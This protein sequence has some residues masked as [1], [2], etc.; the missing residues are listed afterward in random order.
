MS[1]PQIRCDHDQIQKISSQ[2]SA[3]S[4][5][6]AGINRKLKSA[7]ATL[8]GGDW[9]G[10]GATQFLKEMNNEINPA[11]KRLQKAMDEAAKVTKQVSQAFKDAEEESSRIL[12]IIRT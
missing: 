4:S 3:Q 8:E 12:I 10:R 11:M 7:R 1:A 2:F 5:A 9:I 6:I